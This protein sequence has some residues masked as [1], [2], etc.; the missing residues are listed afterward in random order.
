[1]HV[2]NYAYNES[3]YGLSLDAK[4]IDGYAVVVGKSKER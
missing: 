2:T 3:D 1:M 4:I